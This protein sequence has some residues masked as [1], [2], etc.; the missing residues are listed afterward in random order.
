MGKLFALKAPQAKMM[1]NIWDAADA[2]TPDPAYQ[3]DVP[4]MTAA[5]TAWEHGETLWLVGP[6]GS[7]KGTLCREYAAR[8]RRP[9]VRIGFERST[10][11]VDLRG[12]SEPVP[13]ETH[14]AQ[15]VWVDKVF[16]AS[17]RRPGTFILLDEITTAPAGTVAWY[18]TVLDERQITLPTGEIVH[19]APGVIVAIAD[20]TAGYGDPTGAYAGTAP[21]N[22]ALIDRCSRMVYVDYLP[23]A[24]EALALHKRTG[25]PFPAAERLAKFA[26][27]VR[28]D[29]AKAG[30]EARA[31]SYRRIVAFA[32]ATF[33]DRIDAPTAWETTAF[34]RL[35]DADREALRQ[36]VRIDFKLDDYLAEMNGATVPA[37]STA[38]VSQAAE[39][40]NARD[41]FARS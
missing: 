39:Q 38:P 10:E 7:G 17:V 13:G 27:K 9:F 6:M 1:A 24:K 5:V 4:T 25:I 36:A 23:P 34:S 26:A 14:G 3:V 37:A 40:V 18:Q 31:F 41:V 35:P 2:L 21:A 30:G 29:Q 20:N 22:A 11:V 28:A 12:Q 16:T 15:M 19:F 8:T 33:R 32:L